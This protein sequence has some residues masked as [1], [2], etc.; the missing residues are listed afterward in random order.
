MRCDTGNVS[1]PNITRAEARALQIVTIKKVSRILIEKNG[2]AG[3]SLREVAR[4]MGVVSSALYRYFATR[5]DLLTALI[6][7]AYNDLGA[8]VERADARAADE[9]AESR[10]RVAARAIRRWAKRNPHEYG[11]IFGTPVP[12]YVAPTITIEAATRVPRVLGR[13]LSDAHRGRA[14][15][16]NANSRKEVEGFIEVEALSEALSGVPVDTYVRALMAWN[17]IFGFISFELWGHYVGSV[18]NANVMFERV[19]DE[20]IG[21]LGL[22]AGH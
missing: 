16:Q 10:F 17:L 18:K 22:P 3:L 5:D 8:S 14:I 6:Y 21:L 1:S 7:D 2:V 4:E 15:D 19:L 9:S 20:L 13:I 12:N 11:L